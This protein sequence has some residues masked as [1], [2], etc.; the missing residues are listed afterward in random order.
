MLDMAIENPSEIL[1]VNG[2]QHELYSEYLKRHP[3]Y[4][5]ELIEERAKVYQ[6]L[7]WEVQP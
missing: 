6:K 1:M 7:G 5:L 2:D 3:E 4:L